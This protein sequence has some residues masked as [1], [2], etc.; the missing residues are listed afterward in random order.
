MPWDLCG[1]PKILRVTSA[2]AVLDEGA[3]GM[4]PQTRRGGLPGWILL[5]LL[6][7]LP[8]LNLVQP[9]A[10]EPFFSARSA[11]ERPPGRTGSLPCSGA[12]SPETVSVAPNAASP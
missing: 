12:P 11:R 7:L 10:R 8:N 3:G 6:L 2:H 1:F 9:P 4:D 5:L